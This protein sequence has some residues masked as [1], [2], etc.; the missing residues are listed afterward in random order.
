MI[1]N[2]KKDYN[3]IINVLESCTKQGQ[4]DTTEK[5]YKQFKHKWSNLF[6]SK[7]NQIDK[8]TYECDEKYQI[9]LTHKRNTLGW[10]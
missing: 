6:K 5:C 10:N 9:I 7:D 4:L 1:E 8:L 2:F 3:W